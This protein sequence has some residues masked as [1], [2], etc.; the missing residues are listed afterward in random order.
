MDDR[1]TFPSCI[2]ARTCGTGSTPTGGTETVCECTTARR[3]G[4]QKN[5]RP[6]ALEPDARKNARIGGVSG[7]GTLPP[8][9]V[10]HSPRRRFDQIAQKF[11]SRQTAHAALGGAGV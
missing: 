5:E 8:R 6:D 11:G 1:R 10:G 4:K 2:S 7:G 3:V 9:G